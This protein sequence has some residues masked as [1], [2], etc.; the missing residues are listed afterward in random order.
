MSQEEQ[1]LRIDY[2]EWAVRDLSRAKE[3]YQRVFGWQFTD[4][5]PDYASFD[6]GRMRGGLRSDLEQRPGG[7]L[8]V[9]YSHELEATEQQ[10][11]QHGGTIVKE[12]FEFP[13]GR[14][15]HFADPDGC[16]LAVWSDR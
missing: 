5:G 6:D 13:G 9:I 14:R 2:V 3:F 1:H 12:T 16:E 4:Y 11:K 15:F 8:L 10:V 7:P